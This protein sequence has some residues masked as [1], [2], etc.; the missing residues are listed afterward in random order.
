[1]CQVLD[2]TYVFD[3]YGRPHSVRGGVTVMLR[4]FGRGCL[5]KITGAAP[6]TLRPMGIP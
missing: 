3:G 2:G 1:M 6:N 5:R 4:K